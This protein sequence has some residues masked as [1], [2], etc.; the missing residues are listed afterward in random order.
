[1]ESQLYESFQKV[2]EYQDKYIQDQED[3]FEADRQMRELD[4]A[5]ERLR[6]E[7]M[8]GNESQRHED[9][10]NFVGNSH[11]MGYRQNTGLL[12]HL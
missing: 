7:A 3:I 8:E 10:G 4:K 1:M 12:A 5:I 9:V 6:A 2:Q 11:D